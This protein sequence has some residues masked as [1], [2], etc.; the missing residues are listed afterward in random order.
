M[1][2]LKNVK[3][4]R[5]IQIGFLIIATV[6]TII[7][8]NSFY[9][10]NKATKE[11]EALFTEFLQPQNKIHELDSKF[12]TI[13]FTLMKFSVAAFQSEFAADIKFISKEKTSADSIFKYLSTKEF[14]PKVKKDIEEIQKTW[15]NYKTVVIDAILSAGLMQDYE[16]ASVVA[17]T[18]GEEVS[19]QMKNKFKVVE[20]YLDERGN[21]LS[22]GIT[23]GLY[24]GKILIVVGMVLGT[25]V[26]GLALFFIAPAITN[27]INDFKLAMASFSK[28]NFN[29]DLKVDSKD[30]FG[31]M[32]EMLI[33]FRDAQKEKIKAAEKISAGIFE[34]VTPASAE[35][36]LAICFNKEIDTIEELK[37]E[38]S[39][40]TEA[41]SN[42][43]LTVRGDAQ[44]FEGG[45]KEIVIGMNKTLDTVL[46]PIK[47]GTKVLAVMATGDLTARVEGDYKGDHQLIKNSINA[48]S[49]SLNK[50][51]ME[52]TESVSATA[53]AANQ[54]SSSSEEMAAGAQEQSAQTNEIATAIEQMTKSILD[55]TK[56]T[57]FAAATAKN[58]GEQA[59]KGGMVVHQTIEGMNRISKV[60]E[61]SAEMVF[62]LGKNSDKIGEIIQVI[63]DI[64]D[65]TNL[66]ALNAAIEAARAGEQ[67]RGFAVVADE[68]RKLAERT[69]KATKE[70]ASMIKTIQNDTSEAVQ[71][72]E[73]GTQEVENGKQL[74]NE[75]ENV[76]KDIIEVAQ[77]VSDTVIQ[78]AAASEE[79]SNSSE[80]IS[81]NI[82]GINN[83]TRETSQGISQIARASE[84]LSKLTINL[85][86]L[87]AKFKI[88]KE[89]SRLSVRSN[90]KLIHS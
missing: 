88:A 5:K 30:E 2:N 17:T 73:Q 85:Q 61:K 76:L 22:D 8:I 63:D 23:D 44:K 12:K 50:T 64:A 28:G 80:Q 33:Q 86:E 65:Q 26:F 11:K 72:M 7:A 62:A 70:I 74:A 1:F 20:D 56:N 29:I 71:S 10:M 66:L 46:F 54:I 3:V 69:T 48:V 47:E 75:A 14:D 16:M 59:K 27:P 77:K 21:T 13:Q 83:V 15:V 38:L 41:A 84:D 51:L 32:K 55:N 82:E 37:E 57:S 78:V 40:L 53:S 81:R 34:K 89:T 35:D 25:I 31:E 42:G 43:D 19:A 36:E 18:S 68:V 87:T 60:V 79:Q 67:G 9:Q 24:N 4:I 52:V 58:A 6:S 49:E 45:F 39:H 90:G